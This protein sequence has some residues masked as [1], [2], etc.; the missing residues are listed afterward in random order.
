MKKILQLILLLYGLSFLPGSTGDALAQ[1]QKPLGDVL[2]KVEGVYGAR[3]VYEK[4]LLNGVMVSYQVPETRTKSLENVLKEVLYPKGY[5][6]LYVEKNYYT[7][8]KD[9][10]S[11]AEVPAGSSAERAEVSVT[12]L[13]SKRTVTGTVTDEKGNPLPGVSVKPEG[14]KFGLSTSSDGTFSITFDKSYKTLVFSYVGM[15]PERR[16]LGT[17]SVLNIVLSADENTL[18]EVEVLSTGYQKLEKGQ[19]TG[20]FGY[21]NQKEIAK[22]PAINLLER[23]EGK[24]P[25]VKFDIRNNTVN[26]RGQN[27]YAANGSQPLI[28]ID[29][30]PLQATNNETQQ[31]TALSNSTS[32]GYALLSRIN[33]NDIESITFLK[34]AAASSIWGSGA[35]NGVIVIETKKGR[36]NEPTINVNSSL[37]ISGVANFSKINRMSSAQYID[38]ESE[39][40]EKGFITD[41]ASWTPGYYTFNTNANTS[42]AMEWMFRVKRG[43]ATAS[44]RDSALTVLSGNDNTQQIKDYLLQKAVAQQYNLSLSGGGDKSTYYISAN[45]TNDR[46]VYRNNEATSYNFTANNTNEFFKKR[47]VLSTGLTYNNTNSKINT[48]ANTAMGNSTLGLRPYDMLVD[49]N[50]NHINRYLLFRPEVIDNFTKL[51]YLPWTYNSIDELNY[52]NSIIKENRIRV[53]VG[54]K[55]KATSWLDIDLNGNYQNSTSETINEDE[56]NSYNARTLINSA[57]SVSSAGKLVYGVPMGGIYRSTNSTGTD[58]A[59]RGNLNIHKTFNEI[60]QLNMIAGTEIRQS[61]YKSSSQT[62]YGFNDDTYL[63]TSVNPTIYYQTVYPWTSYIGATDGTVTLKKVRYLS[64]FS[65]AN[66][67]LYNK[68]F[69]SASVRFEDYTSVGAS[70][71]LTKRPFWSAGLKWKVSGEDFMK[72]IHAVNDLNLRL[73]YGTGGR[74]PSGGLNE[75]VIN[76]SSND[77]LTGLPYA[78]ISSPANDMLSW[79]LTKQLNGGLDLTMLN[80]RMTLNFDIYSKRSSGILVSLPYNGTYGWTSLTYNAAT[81]SSHGLEFGIQGSLVRKKDWGWNTNLNFAY[82]NNRV[83]DS[84]FTKNTSLSLVS[85]STPM[86]DYSLDYLFVYRW[87]G[88]DNTG[89]SQIYDKNNNIVKSTTGNANLT[90]DDLKYAGRRSSPYYGGWSND[91]NYKNFS[92]NVM[93][94]YYLGGHFLKS[95]VSNY[96]TYAGL[97][98]GVIG[99]Q[100][101]LADRWRNPGDEAFTNVPGLSNINTNS[102][103]RYQYSDLLV[104]SSSYVRLQQIA[105]SYSL[106][107]KV[108]SRTPF[109][110]LSASVSARNLGL[111]WTK[112]KDGIDPDYVNKNTYSNLPPTKNYVF[113]INATF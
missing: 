27:T 109:K 46:P 44:Q 49:A 15:A 34:D 12:G 26:I 48:A 19:V 33:P 96:P 25:G 40:V 32:S 18:K 67:G 62:R 22:T 81:L 74:I 59:V 16:E 6:F 93:M 52:S 4:D 72:S 76:I 71:S 89:Q 56:Q 95:S 42:D 77:P 11:M 92:L 84:R 94:S 17:G 111:L 8:V 78:A 10:R 87:A 101:D 103:N 69:A 47:I 64:Y 97:Y 104:R 102:I 83:T 58:F 14:S 55:A 57:T 88:L 13:Q 23:L 65:N 41:P 110:A 45:A 53:N 36:K 29:G 31:L 99:T 35:A 82:N 51:G 1:S 108:I 113:G 106:P 80:N 37:S 2:K 63:S 86:I 98:Q 100:S 105:L 73:T 70:E 30:F 60:H 43:T 3:F 20:A 68:Y 9:P 39:L 85:S 38:L 112:N 91:F 107:A 61:T 79:E 66:Y 90:S 5:L 54:L 24:V 28:V 50:G 75:S 21:V 7:I